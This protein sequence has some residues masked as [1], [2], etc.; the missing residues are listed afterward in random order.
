MNGI[1]NLAFL[2]GLKIVSC[3][4][5]KNIESIFDCKNLESLVLGKLKIKSLEGI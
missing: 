3:A 4:N 1:Q 5:L 2:A